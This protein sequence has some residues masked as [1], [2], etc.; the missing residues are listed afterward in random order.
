MRLHSGWLWTAAKTPAL[1][2]LDHLAVPLKL[3]QV[4]TLI[5]EAFAVLDAYAQNTENMRGGFEIR[6]TTGLELLDVNVHAFSLLWALP[7]SGS[8]KIQRYR[9]CRRPGTNR[10]MGGGFPAFV[11]YGGSVHIEDCEFAHNFDDLTDVGS[12]LGFAF[13]QVSGLTILAFTYPGQ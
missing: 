11:M 8:V 7:L 9:A 5:I 3:P 13:K 2:H 1:Q 12:E 10:L 4:L 6:D